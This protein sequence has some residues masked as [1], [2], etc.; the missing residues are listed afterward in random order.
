MRTT[1]F[2]RWHED[3]YEDG[4]QDDK[5]LEE[6]GDHAHEDQGREGGKHSGGLLV[7]CLFDKDGRRAFKHQSFVLHEGGGAGVNFA[8]F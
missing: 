4:S 8:L 2:G 3:A 5:E 6:K 1:R 7:V